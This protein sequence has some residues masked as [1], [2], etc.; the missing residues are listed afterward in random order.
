MRRDVMYTT[1]ENLYR[2]ADFS[3][4]CTLCYLGFEIDGFERDQK[5]PGRINT[6]FKRSDE[7]DAALQSLWGKELTVEPISFLEMTRTV[8]A[9]LRDSN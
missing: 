6:F 7:L 8:K 1:S 9:R 3:T 5:S 4:I 2:T